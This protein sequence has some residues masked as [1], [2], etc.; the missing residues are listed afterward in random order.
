MLEDYRYKL[1]ADRP[2]HQT[3]VVPKSASVWR[4]KFITYVTEEVEPSAAFRIDH[5]GVKQH[6]AAGNKQ[7]LASAWIYWAIGGTPFQANRFNFCHP[8]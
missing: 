8:Q 1:Y 3:H 4:Y 2:L 5:I 6:A 7:Q